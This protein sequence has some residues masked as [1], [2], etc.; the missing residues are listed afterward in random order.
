MPDVKLSQLAAQ[1]P[2]TRA[3][4]AA[5][6]TH[7]GHIDGLKMEWVSGTSLRVTSGSAYIESLGYAI[8]LP[9]A[10][11]KSSLVLVASSWYHIYLFDNAGTPDIE[12]VT[13]APAA[14][15]NGSARSKTGD[16]G[17]RW[18][19]RVR[20]DESSALR[21]S[22]D[23]R[24]CLATL[25]DPNAA[26][27]SFHTLPSGVITPIPFGYTKFDPYGMFSLASPTELVIP[28]GVTRVRVSLSC[29]FNSSAAGVRLAFASKNG[30]DFGGRPAQRILATGAIDYLNAVSGFTEVTPGDAFALQ[31]L[32]GSGADLSAACSYGAGTWM[33]IAVVVDEYAAR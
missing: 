3:A 28:Q 17:K 29:S 33:D 18:L 24:G 22:L 31:A 20:T 27:S 5:L 32:Q 25:S 6:W 19:G 14:P 26:V 2:P 30:N 8:E 12:I 13:T 7:R 4:G 11:T 16:T 23:T 21:G 9:A 10:I 1:S 15:Y